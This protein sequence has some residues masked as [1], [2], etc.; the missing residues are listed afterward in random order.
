[1]KR[2]MTN[3]TAS[4]SPADPGLALASCALA[5]ALSCDTGGV[6][7]LVVTCHPVRYA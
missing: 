6:S 5:G 7:L 1:L 3:N 4:A 2:A